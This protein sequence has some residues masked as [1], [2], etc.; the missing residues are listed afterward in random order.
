[1]ILMQMVKDQWLPGISEQGGMTVW[2]TE[3]LEDSE[4]TP[5]DTIMMD[6]CHYT[7]VQIH[8]MYS[9]ESGP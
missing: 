8:R 1:M 5:D 7:H 2:S 9:S 4:N 6:T 3:G